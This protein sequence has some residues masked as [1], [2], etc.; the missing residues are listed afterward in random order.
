MPSPTEKAGVPAGPDDATGFKNMQQLI[1]LRW[2]AAVGQ[3]LTIGVVYYGFGVP[4]PVDQMLAVLG[5]LVAFNG[6]SLMR[7]HQYREV[8]NAELF[9]ASLVD[10][11][12]LTTQLYLSGGVTNP[13]VFLYL[14]QIILGAVLLEAWSTWIMVAVTTAC[15]ASLARFGRPLA[16]P[17]DLDRGLASPYVQGVLV[18]FVI[19]AALVVIFITRI[20]RNLRERDARLAGL[21]QRAAEEEH[22]VRMGLLAS[23]AAH[24][25]GTPLATLAVILGDWRRMPAFKADAELLQEV[26][27]M[28]LQVQRCKTIVSGI[29]LSAGEARGESSARTTICNF[30]DG[31]VEEWRS[32]RPT[33]ALTYENRFGHDMPMVSD[34]AVKQMICNVLDN[35]L[36]ASAHALRLEV[37]READ[38][39]VLT[40]TDDGPGFAPA[41]L[42]HLGKPYQ[43]SKG[44]PGGGLGLFLVVNVA[45][46]IGGSVTARNRPEGGAAVTISL[47][48]AAITLEE[49]EAHAS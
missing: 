15:F 34:S 27:E 12:M 37:T 36:E 7:W 17:L 5:C 23:G 11:G 20:S 39:L 8:T 38:T 16:L 48:L 6:V 24:E 43:S 22:I 46:T 31:L 40:C 42:A 49:D 10:V 29:L 1:Q 4:L 47:P 19:N 30:L 33:A 18:C 25:L 13:F 21:R 35:A 26:G 9:V 3:V 28:Q 45:R 41:M 2:I 32:T 44:R 14:L